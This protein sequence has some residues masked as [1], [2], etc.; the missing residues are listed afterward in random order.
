MRI[1]LGGKG[2]APEKD[3]PLQAHLKPLSDFISFF[4]TLQLVIE[5]EPNQM[6][7]VF[8]ASHIWSQIAIAW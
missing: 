1:K 4:E 6:W 2:Y 7:A 8:H 3:C 5:E